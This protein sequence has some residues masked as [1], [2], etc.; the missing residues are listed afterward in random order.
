M[1]EPAAPQDA[2]EWRRFE[3]R[4][5]DQHAVRRSA[6]AAAMMRANGSR[7]ARMSSRTSSST[8]EDAGHSSRGAGPCPGT[9]GEGLE[10][11]LGGTPAPPRPARASG[12]RRSRCR[13]PVAQRRERRGD[14]R[15]ATSTVSSGVSSSGASGRRRAVPASAA[16]GLT[17]WAR[18]P[19]RFTVPGA[20]GGTYDSRHKGGAAAAGR[21]RRGSPGRPPEA[22]RRPAAISVRPGRSTNPRIGSVI[23]CLPPRRSRS[24][25]SPP[26]RARRASVSGAG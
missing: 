12:S 22:A 16:T 1:R 14:R 15:A 7:P 17:H 2:V 9:A 19:S 13:F 24:Q 26:P 8:R 21:S 4:A 10:H 25:R 18:P 23:A 11:A 20:A 6:S 3:R 5:E